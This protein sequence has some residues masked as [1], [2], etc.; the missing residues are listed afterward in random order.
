MLSHCAN[1]QC[2]KPFLHLREGK[3][4]LVEAKEAHAAERISF[5]SRK[6]PQRVERFWLCDRCAPVWTLI[7]DASRGITLIPLRQPIVAE[8]ESLTDPFRHAISIR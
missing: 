2:L 6:P 1:P 7:H 5:S 8:K 3:L 4:F